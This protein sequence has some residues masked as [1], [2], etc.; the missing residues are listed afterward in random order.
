MLTL[1]PLAPI[2]ATL[3]NDA[4]SASTQLPAGD[5]AH[6]VVLLVFIFLFPLQTSDLKLTVGPL[7]KLYINH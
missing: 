1:H 6:L 3:M 2:M 4:V 5:G 7:F